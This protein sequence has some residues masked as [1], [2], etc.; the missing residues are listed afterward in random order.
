M[1]KISAAVTLVILFTLLQMSPRVHVPDAGIYTLFIMAPFVL[2]YAVDVIFKFE[3]PSK[4]GFD[5]GR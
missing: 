5:E 1:K 3:D 2:I 4:K